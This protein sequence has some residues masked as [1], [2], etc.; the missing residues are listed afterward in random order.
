MLAHEATLTLKEASSRLGVHPNTLRNWEEQ[1][2]I[3]LVRL[4]GS[5]HR[6]V[7]LSEVE[8]LLAQ[9]HGRKAG[10]NVRLEPPPSDG[11]I[12]AEGKAMA[13]TIQSELATLALPQTLPE[14]M[15]SLRGRSWSS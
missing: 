2:V 9:M 8:R 3:R 10:A 5:R 12:I 7:P 4:P 11:A 6:R 13:L 15:Q 1:G 14:A